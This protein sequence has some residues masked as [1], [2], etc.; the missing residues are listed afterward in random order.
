MNKDIFGSV[1]GGRREGSIL[2]YF[3]FIWWS[4]E[5]LTTAAGIR[6]GENALSLTSRNTFLTAKAE[7]SNV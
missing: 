5:S 1:E 7:R 3:V 6:R 2:V 4:V